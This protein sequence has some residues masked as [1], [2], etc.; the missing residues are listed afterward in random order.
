MYGILKKQ[1]ATICDTERNFITNA[2]NFTALLFN[3]LS[4]INWVGFYF[5]NNGALKLGP[6]QGKPACIDISLGKGVCGTSAQREEAIIVDDVHEFPG[7]IAC[8]EK[9]R[10]ELVIPLHFNNII[11]GVLDIDSP[12]KSRF[13]EADKNGIEELLDILIENSDIEKIRPAF[14]F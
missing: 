7:H 2:S 3:N 12:V 4:D 6:F 1:L 11:I 8:D 10:S 13:S 9:S 5:M 14:Q